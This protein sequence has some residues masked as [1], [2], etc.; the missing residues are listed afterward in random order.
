MGEG[1]PPPAFAGCELGS[2]GYLLLANMTA[3]MYSKRTPVYCTILHC[4]LVADDIFTY[5]VPST[6]IE[7]LDMCCNKSVGWQ[8]Q[9]WSEITGA[10]MFRQAQN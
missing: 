2:L 9:Q 6:D 10:V 7:A 5:G 4:R 3:D 8:D 1:R